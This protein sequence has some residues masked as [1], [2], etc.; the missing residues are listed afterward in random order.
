MI[1]QGPAGGGPLAP[2]HAGGT[3]HEPQHHR[4][5]R[6]VALHVTRHVTRHQPL[7]LLVPVDDRTGQ[8]RGPAAGLPG[9]H[10]DDAVAGRRCRDLGIVAAQHARDGGGDEGR[11]ELEREGRRHRRIVSGGL[12]AVAAGASAYVGYGRVS[13]CREVRG[14]FIAG[15]PGGM[16]PYGSYPPPQGGSYPPPQGGSYPPPQGPPPQGP[17]PQGP[18]PQGPPPQGPPPQGPPPQGFAPPVGAQNG[19]CTAQLTCDQGLVCAGMPDHT[20]RCMPVRPVAPS[21]PPSIG[22]QNGACTAQ[23]AC[24][25]GLVCAGMPDHT[26][27]CMPEP[28]AG[29]HGGACMANNACG[30]GLVCAGMPDHTNR[31]MPA[32]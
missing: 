14:Q 21:P 19:S 9:L 27:R 3:V 11:V 24:D 1:A 31:C 15:H 12:L 10:A 17:P 28:A 26:N 25:P 13:R 32:R 4:V 30:A 6:R 2:D 29:T 8:R 18:P 16:Q 22:A 20:N 23:L 7:G 5:A